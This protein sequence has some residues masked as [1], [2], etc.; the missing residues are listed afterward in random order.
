MGC[1]HHCHDN[2]VGGRHTIAGEK[3]NIALRPYSIGRWNANADGSPMKQFP[4]NVTAAK[5][6]LVRQTEQALHSSVKDP[7]ANQSRD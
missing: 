1:V 4:R 6:A 5:V 3:V 7:A 2:T